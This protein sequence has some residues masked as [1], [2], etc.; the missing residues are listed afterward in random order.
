E[1]AGDA[2]RP[3][4]DRAVLER[5]AAQARDQVASARREADELRGNLDA[6]RESLPDVAEA[7]EAVEVARRELTR[8]EE[9]GRVIDETIRLL[10]AAE[11][12]VHRDVAPVLAGAVTR[13]LP[14][15]SDGAYSEA[16]V[17]PA[18]LAVR[19]KEAATGE[20]RDARLLSEGTREQIYLLLRVAMAQHLV[21]TGETAPLLLDEVTVQSDPDRKRR[22]LDVLHALSAERQVVLFTHDDD[23]VGWAEGCLDGERDALVRLSARAA[24][25][26]GAPA[27]RAAGD[28][29][30]A[31]VGADGRIG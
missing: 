22:L 30:L 3:S 18:T 13:W 8:V 16:S 19:V 14:T 4:G 20:W 2:P 10:R 31:Q 17:D 15:I 5:H 23:V 26:G 12:R 27:L 24:S 25:N 7:E 1:A 6:R 28:A 9:L 21:T 11:E 29:G